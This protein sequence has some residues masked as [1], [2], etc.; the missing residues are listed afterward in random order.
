[1]GA[2]D[3]AVVIVNYNAGEYLAPCVA[4]VVAAAGGLA[5]DVVVVDNDSHDDSVERVRALQRPEVRI[6]ENPTNRG[7]SA[8]WNQGAA[9][10]DAPWLLFLNPDAEVSGGDLAAFVA[11]GERRPDVAMLGPVI[12]NADGSI[13]ESGRVFPGVVQAL[14]HAFLGPFVPNNRFTTS[15][16][17]TAWDRTTAREVD[18]VSGAA[19][20]VRRL[21]FEEVDGFDESFWLYG[22]ELDIGTRLRD[23]GWKVLATPELE[24]VHVGGVSTGRS[25]R[26][27][28]M[29]SQSVYRYYRK[30]RA[31]GWRRATLPIAWAALRLRAEVVTLRE[32][33]A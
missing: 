20:L 16:R 19:M 28:V 29:H 11:A 3:L 7:L 14:G 32:R 25:R 5:V 4:S 15:Y 13:Y 2:G 6:I 30:H 26:T 9:L 8:A 31:M 27:H 12:R 24:I 17:Q 22:E 1:M 21:A 10:V 18:W 23:A 33:R